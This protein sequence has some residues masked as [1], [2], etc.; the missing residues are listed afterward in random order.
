MEG[1]EN[2]YIGVYIYHD[3]TRVSVE[4]TTARH[5]SEMRIQEL[6]LFRFSTERKPVQT[7]LKLLV[8]SRES[9]LG[10]KA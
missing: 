10:T 5:Y 9:I 7:S 4:A 2:L 1:I 3:R 8:T 6:H